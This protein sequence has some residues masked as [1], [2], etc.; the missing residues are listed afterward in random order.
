ME[1]LRSE[2]LN[3]KVNN[4]DVSVNSINKVGVI[5]DIFE[6]KRNNKTIYGCDVQY[7]TYKQ[8]YVLDFVKEKCLANL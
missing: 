1:K 8:G 2:F 6:L 7:P 3:K 4:P 5:V